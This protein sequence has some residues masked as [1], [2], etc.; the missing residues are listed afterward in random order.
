MKAKILSM[1]VVFFAMTLMSATAPNAVLK[2]VSVIDKEQ[3][4]N[5]LNLQ[6]VATT[7]QPTWEKVMNEIEAK[8]GS[9]LNWKE[10]LAFK[11]LKK[12]VESKMKPDG[13][14]KTKAIDVVGFILGFLL[15]LIGVLLAYIIDKE[16]YIP[17]AWYGFLAAVVLYL[18][19]FLVVFSSI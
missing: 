10:K 17:S 6:P 5:K 14:K 12:K 11:L 18:V 8:K 9:K 15:G 1:L 7:A 19:L 13:K 2:T 4:A 3:L 16:K